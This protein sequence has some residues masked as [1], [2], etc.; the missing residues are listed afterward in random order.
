MTA[1][2]AYVSIG[3]NIDRHANIRG[4]LGKLSSNLGELVVSPIYESKSL[5]F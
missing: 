1:T 2:R 4:G 3:S 5:W